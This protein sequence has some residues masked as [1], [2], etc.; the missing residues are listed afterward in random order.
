M[1]TVLSAAWFTA[2]AVAML[3]AWRAYEHV[4][5]R[6]WPDGNWLEIQDVP[7]WVALLAILAVYALVAIPVGAAR[8]ATLYYANGG[9]L[10]GWADAWSGLLWIAMVALLLLAAWHLLPQ[11]HELLRGVMD[12][13]VP[14]PVLNL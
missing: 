7:R 3:A 2:M 13:H 11:L 5:F 9:R 12:R 6:A 4:N 8:K 14:N 10:H 1:F